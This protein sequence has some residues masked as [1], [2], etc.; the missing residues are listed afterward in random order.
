MFL[1]CDTINHMEQKIYEYFAAPQPGTDL[2]ANSF[3]SYWNNRAIRIYSNR[4]EEWKNNILERSYPISDFTGFLNADILTGTLTTGQITFILIKKKEH[5]SFYEKWILPAIYGDSV[6]S[7]IAS[8]LRQNAS[9]S[10]DESKATDFEEALLKIA[11]RVSN[12]N[13]INRRWG[14]FWRFLAIKMGFIVIFSIII[15]ALFLLIAKSRTTM[16]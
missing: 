6:Y 2:L 14:N 10:I 13:F 3:N 12:E 5:L 1:S 4:I 9:F 8:V 15:F 11:P 7:N 16:P